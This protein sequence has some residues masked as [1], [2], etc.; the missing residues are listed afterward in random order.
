MLEINEYKK[1]YL[2]YYFIQKGDFIA[3]TISKYI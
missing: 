3:K 1:C 2:G